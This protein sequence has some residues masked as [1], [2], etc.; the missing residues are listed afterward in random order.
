MLIKEFYNSP[1]I[2]ISSQYSIVSHS[3]EEFKY[4]CDF[5]M[6]VIYYNYLT[7][8]GNLLTFTQKLKSLYRSLFLCPLTYT[9][10]TTWCYNATNRC[11]ATVIAGLQC[12]VVKCVCAHV[13]MCVCMH[14]C[15]RSIH[16]QVVPTQ[17][18]EFHLS[19]IPLTYPQTHTHACTHTHTH[20]HT[21][22]YTNTLNHFAL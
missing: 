22:M 4:K 14:V 10:F 5:P 8:N 9:Q 6:Y 2:H 7:I 18:L 17:I 13:C 3:Y 21:H 15:S 16:T 19:T 20:I 1:A 11:I 12:K